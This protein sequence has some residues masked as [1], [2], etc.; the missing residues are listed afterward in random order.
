MY[1][2]SEKDNFIRREIMKEEGYFQGKLDDV[3]NQ[4][5]KDEH[6]TQEEQQKQQQETEKAKKLAC[7]TFDF[8]DDTKSTHEFVKR[9]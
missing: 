4:K 7:K 5:K 9:S 8:D 1:L 3:L 6:Q 2:G